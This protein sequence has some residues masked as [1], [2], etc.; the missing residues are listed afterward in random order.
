MDVFSNLGIEKLTESIL[1]KRGSSGKAFSYGSIL[2]SV[3]FGYL[4]GSECLEEINTLVENFRQ[5][6]KAVQLGADMVGRG[7]KEFAEKDT[8]YKSDSSCICMLNK[9]TSFKVKKLYS[10]C[11]INGR[12]EVKLFGGNGKR[13]R[14]SLEVLYFLSVSFVC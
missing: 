14:F 9:S 3:F 11:Q 4:C 10:F 7:L 2:A 1:G 12:V 13:Y 5:K 6:Q 8:V